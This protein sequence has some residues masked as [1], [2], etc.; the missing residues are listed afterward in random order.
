[1]KSHTSLIVLV[2]LLVAGTVTYALLPHPLPGGDGAYALAAGNTPT[3]TPTPMPLPVRPGYTPVPQDVPAPRVIQRSP[4]AGEE[5]PSSGRIEL[6]FDQPMDR[7]SVEAAFVLS[8]SLPGRFDW[9]DDRTVRFTPDGLTRGAQYGVAL[10]QAAKS[11]GGVPLREP[12]T[13]RFA[14]I[15]FLEVSQVI[16]ADGSRDIDPVAGTLTVMFNRP[17]VPLTSLAQ[18]AGF[19]QPLEITP[20]LAGSGEWVNT[21]VYVFRPTAQLAGGTTYRARVKAGL[22]DTTG[23]LLASDYEWTFSTAPPAVVRSD[24]QDGATLVGVRP[25][26]QVQFNM[27]IDMQSAAESF[28]LLGNRQEVVGELSVVGST[29]IFTPAEQLAFDTTYLVQVKAGLRAADSG[30]R[31]MQQDFAARF[32]TVPLPALVSTDPRNGEQNAYPYTGLTLYFNA[33]IDPVT[34]LSHVNFSPN[35]TSTAVYTYYSDWDRSFHIQ[36]GAQPSTSYWAS[37][38]PGIKDPYGNA[39]REEMRVV[40]RT[41]PLSPDFRLHVPEFVGTYDA[42]LPARVILAYVNITRVDL[43]LYRLDPTMVTLH[44]WEWEDYP[45]TKAV[46]VRQ[47]RQMLEAPLNKQSYSRLDLVDG[48]GTLAPGVYLLQADSPDVSDNRYNRWGRWHILVVSDVN[49]TLKAGARDALVWATNLS[50]GTPARGL[51]VNLYDTDNG[52]DLGAQVTD[53]QG[54]ARFNMV[55]GYRSELVAYSLDPFA[56][57]SSRWVRGTSVWDFGLPGA[58]G[59]QDTR[60]VVYTDR[61]IYRPGQMVKIKG[62]ARVEDDA[63][64]GLAEAGEVKVSVTDANYETVLERYLALNANGTFETTL[65]VPEGAPLGEYGISTEFLG[66]GFRHSFQVA[67]YRPPE[68]QVVVTPGQDEGRLDEPLDATVDV[69]YFFGGPVAGVPVQWAVLAET[70]IFKPAWGGGYTFTDGDDPWF[71]FDCWWNPAPPPRPILSGRGVT[72]DAG[73]L[74][75]TLPAELTDADGNPLTRSTRL[76]IEATVTGRDN[77]AVSGRAHSVRHQGEYYVGLRTRQYVGEAGKPFAVDLITVDWAGERLAGTPISLSIYRREWINKFIENEA[78]GGRWEYEQK[79]VLIDTIATTA[80]NNGEAVTTFTPPQAGTYRLVAQGK[81]ETGREIRSSLFVWA[82]GEQAASWRRENNDRINLI[83]DR[84]SY[85]P[86][87]I[88]EILI[89]SPFTQTHYALVTVERGRIKRHEVVRL[90]TNNYL[91]RLPIQ[92]SDAP[93]V[94]VSVVLVNGRHDGQP[95][96]HKVGLLPLDVSTQQQELTVSVTPRS[97]RAEPGSRLEYAVKVTDKRGEPVQAELS[98]DLVDKAVLSLL[99]RQPNALREAFYFRRG[100]NVETAAGL[101]IAVNRRLA[102]ME[103]DLGLAMQDEETEAMADGAMPTP[104]GTA[105]PAPA[106]AMEK[107][108]AEGMRQAAAPAGVTLRQEFSDTAYWNPV[109]LTDQRGEARVT[110]QLPDNITTWVMRGVAVNVATQVGE[111]LSEIVATKPLLVRPIAP[112]FLVSGDRVV[113]G[114]AV[115]NNTD[116]DLDVEVSLAATGITLLDPATRTVTIAAGREASVRWSTRATDAPYA[117]LVFAAVAAD[118]GYSDASKPR[119]ATGPDGALAIFRYS[120]PDIV[121]TAGVLSEGGSVTE[122]VALPPAYDDRRGD[123]QVHIDPSL[124]AGIRTG[125]TYLEHFPYECTEQTASRFLPNVLTYRALQQLGVA[126]AELRARLPRLVEQGLVKLYRQQNADGGWGWWANRESNVHITAYVVFGMLKARA[127]DIMVDEDALQRGV[128]FLQASLA[129]PRE[130]RDVYHANQQAWVLYVLAEA[131]QARTNDL[132]RLFTQRHQL[133]IYG[134]AFLAMA[135]QLHQGASDRTATLLADLNSAAIL[136]ATGIHWEEAVTDWWAM[137]SDT[138]TTAIVLD[139]LVRLDPQNGLIPNVA[140]WLMIAR[141]ADV[142]STTQE[143]AWALIALTDWMVQTGE[144]Q[145]AYDFAV[146]LNGETIASGEVDA[147]NVDTSVH[148]D[149]NIA[150]LLPGIANR[151]M[152]SRSE[153]PGRLYYTAHLRVFLPVEDLPAL[154]RGIIVQ[155]RY[156]LAACQDGPRCPEVREARAGDVIRVDLTLIAPND[157][158][159]LVVEDMLPAGAEAIDTGLATTSMLAMDPQLTRGSRYDEIEGYRPYWM[160]WWNWYS[161]TELRDE[162]VVLFADYLPR[163]TYEYSYTMRA[164][165]AGDFHV[166]PTLAWQFYFPEVFGRSEGRMLYIGQP[167]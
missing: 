90:T 76:T 89:P 64:F 78:G 108:A 134:Q 16:P 145:A 45:L 91:Y 70:Y 22:S 49:L 85:Q 98:L 51:V 19:P 132:T 24:P 117:D 41:A 128:G 2:T 94:Y 136:S 110:V 62:V 96:E 121:G 21:S 17:V 114:A 46:L 148:A 131:G 6:V 4:Q 52:V 38:S 103:L 3:L 144:L 14:T 50:D 152:I 161:R 167:E 147:D 59:W 139:A 120:A 7:A 33:P 160:W 10:S 129:A 40:F 101:A 156:T 67:A 20:P 48:G 150:D 61:P 43:S 107:S 79:D 55:T 72:D 95:A 32:T 104:L 8:P 151:L 30:D 126:D 86:G 82:T 130:V 12:Y 66:Q 143:T 37:I 69:T 68:F 42:A 39:T 149:V 93:N 115:S 44:E 77:Q 99:P 83:S 137:N 13:F 140:R 81:S 26:I 111:G 133:S 119:L 112:R 155:R 138:R 36:F 109:V 141:R 92:P 88:A 164:V 54:V 166:I 158:H 106:M 25:R 123:L 11:Q 142:W 157:L 146:T 165:T 73:R 63:A 71:C 29:V 80:D 124:A 84:S 1:M 56:A 47:W 163:G 100:L 58:Y 159:Y 122:L 15:G 102:E 9:G 23:G 28:R 87:D 74:K 127:A 118:G 125:L 34:V 116:R 113:L 65:D 18:Q 75:I 5:L 153:G 60:V 105:V 57:V 31:G 97:D 135:L 162:K 154:D 53:D 35:V 27:P